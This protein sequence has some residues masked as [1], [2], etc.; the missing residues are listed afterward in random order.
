MR[1]IVAALVVGGVV[2]GG[3]LAMA[4]SLGGVQ[5][6]NL[7]SGVALVSSCD[8]DGVSVRYWAG[9]P[10]ED[11]LVRYVTVGGIDPDCDGGDLFVALLRDGQDPVRGAGPLS[12]DP[13]ESEETAEMDE[14]V[15]PED[16]VGVR[17]VIRTEGAA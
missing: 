12:L 17:V 13:G 3:A 10:E 15:D 7:G 2:F 4:A 14:A 6:D 9:E 1:R 11:W 8:T 5:A 16:I